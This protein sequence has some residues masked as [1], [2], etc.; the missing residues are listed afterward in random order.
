MVPGLNEA[1]DRNC[2]F[3]MPHR[4]QRRYSANQTRRYTVLCQ[5]S[6]CTTSA[7]R[8]GERSFFLVWLHYPLAAFFPSPLKMLSRI[9][10]YSQSIAKITRITQARSP[11]GWSIYFSDPGNWRAHSHT[12]QHIGVDFAPCIVQKR[13]FPCCRIEIWLSNNVAAIV[14]TDRYDLENTFEAIPKLSQAFAS[15]LGGSLPR[16]TRCYVMLS[17]WVAGLEGYF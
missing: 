16:G 14:S 5:N 4:K 11:V 8:V 1:G 10:R 9:M 7:V 15:S 12:Q 13:D 17:D 2:K 6:R 3:D